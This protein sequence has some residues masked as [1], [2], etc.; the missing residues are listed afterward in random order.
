[1]KDCAPANGLHVDSALIGLEPVAGD[2]RFTMTWDRTRVGGKLERG[3]YKFVRSE[4]GQVLAF[5]VADA[6]EPT[7]SAT[8]EVSNG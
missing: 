7:D 8:P 2:K 3:V 4:N 1:M 6:V 5:H